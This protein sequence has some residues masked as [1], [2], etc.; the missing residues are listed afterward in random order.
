VHVVLGAHACPERS[1]GN[2][3]PYDKLEYMSRKFYHLRG[4]DKGTYDL[5][6]GVRTG[7]GGGC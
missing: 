5:E 7:C 6:Y 2:G 1:Q 3:S 4:N